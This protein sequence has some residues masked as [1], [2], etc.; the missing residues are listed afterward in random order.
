VA[1]V[2]KAVS[3]AVLLFTLFLVYTIPQFVELTSANIMPA[4]PPTVQV[5]IKADGTV[6]P[7][8]TP[9]ERF[10]NRYVFADDLLN[11][12]LTVQR[13]NIVVDGA[14]F[15]LKGV[16][17]NMGITVSGRKNVTIK[18]VYIKNYVSSVWLQQSTN[19]TIRDNVML[20]GFNVILDSSSDNQIT[21]NNIT[22]QDTGYG[23]GVQL[24][25]GSSKNSILRNSFT[26]TGISVRAIDVEHNI[27]SENHFIKDG[28]SVL[29]NG[30]ENTVSKN[31]M[32][33]GRTGVSVTGSGS[34]NSI[35]GNNITGQTKFG[36]K[37]YWGSS[38]TV[39]DNQVTNCS[40]GVRLGFDREYSGREVE[41]NVFF[42]NNFID[43]TQDV[44]VGCLV[45]NNCW[46]K[47]E[48]GNY[49][50]SYN[51]ADTNG[52]GVGDTAYV[53]NENNRLFSAHG[54]R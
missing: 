37:I 21:G 46:N 52:D 26:D 6:E 20:T 12:T 51:G 24:N 36:I 13:D 39:H 29:V 16:G 28:T 23:Y 40:V 31:M 47:G 7:T 54:T 49:W 15:T 1:A 43:N 38:N 50:S 4:P 5:Y 44:F 18:N 2:K 22:G 14:G 25:A 8:T 48:K 11:H 33:N 45:D 19:N 30:D 3:K 42:H 17:V 9:I 27:I 32:V 35:F 53:I 41:D 10:G 34:R